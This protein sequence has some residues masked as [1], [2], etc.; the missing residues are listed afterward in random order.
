[1]LHNIEDGRR[2]R[3]ALIQLLLVCQKVYIKFSSS[4][5]ICIVCFLSLNVID[6]MNNLKKTVLVGINVI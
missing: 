6:M 1:M 4:S 3:K 2:N 5:G